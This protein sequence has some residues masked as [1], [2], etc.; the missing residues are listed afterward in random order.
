MLGV[1]VALLDL[2]GKRGQV[3]LHVLG[4]AEVLV[5]GAILDFGDLLGEEAL[6]VI[7]VCELDLQVL[8]L[9][10]DLGELAGDLLGGGA[11]RGDLLT[12]R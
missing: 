9:P 4:G 2:L 12:L 10:H 5:V 1:V 7:E 8:A 6:G 11:G 3:V